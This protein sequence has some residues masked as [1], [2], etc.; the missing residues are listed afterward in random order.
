[1]VLF[2][3]VIAEPDFTFKVWD[4]M[5]QDLVSW[6]WSLGFGRHLVE[7]AAPVCQLLVIVP[8]AQALE[9]RASPGRLLLKQLYYDLTQAHL[10]A[11]NVD[12]HLVDKG[13]MSI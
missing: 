8:Q 4:P 3:F 9:V 1:L 11:E 13:F 10:K 7:S 12:V 6:V 5:A 2:T